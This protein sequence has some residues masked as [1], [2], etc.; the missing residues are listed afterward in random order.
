[1]YVCH[2]CDKSSLAG[3]NMTCVL[4]FQWLTFPNWDRGVCPLVFLYEKI[5]QF[6][7]KE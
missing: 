5:L 7:G 2:F 6:N 1:M 4:T 3:V